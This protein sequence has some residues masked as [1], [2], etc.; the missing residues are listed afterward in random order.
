[1]RSHAGDPVR[2]TSTGEQCLMK[3]TSSSLA[4]AIYRKAAKISSHVLA[5]SP[6]VESVLLHRSVATGEVI[7]GRSDIDLMLVISRED[8]QDGAKLGSLYR[9][10][11]RLRI[12]IPVLNHIELHEPDGVQNLARIDTFWGSITRRAVMLLSGKA[13]E[14]PVAV[15]EPVHALGRFGL[16]VEW[17][18]AIS[19]QQKNRRNLRKI[20]LESWNACATAEGLI[21]EPYL[22]R[23]EMEAAVLRT[24][25]NIFTRRLSEPS[26][27]TGFVFGLADRLHRQRLPA[28]RKLAKPLIF[29]AITAPLALR[30][31]FVVIPHADE[32]LPPE[33]FA[34]GAFPCTPEVLHLYLHYKNPFLYWVMPR[35]LLDLGMKPPGVQEFLRAC[36]YYSHKR[37]LFQPGFTGGNPASLS[38][39]MELIRHALEWASRGELPPAIP[40]QDIQ[41]RMS[42]VTSCPEY[43]RTVYGPLRREIQWIEESLASLS[44]AADLNGR[45]R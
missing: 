3:V 26:Y 2:H 8:A 42:A 35:P 15:V 32:L 25:R 10:V 9:K 22:L 14:I 38:L 5:G 44:G 19:V 23:S 43:F 45:R 7:F 12:V 20:S 13:V 27:A 24:E 30:R 41:E 40:Q 21:P 18:F 39:Q 34:R 11:Q 31:L 4:A 29:E 28:L 6:M 33:A 16:A 17:F 37:F 1:M 36:R